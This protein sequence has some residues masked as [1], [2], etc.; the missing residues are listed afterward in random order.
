MGVCMGKICGTLT[1]QEAGGGH[2]THEVHSALRLLSGPKLGNAPESP[3]EWMEVL[4]D[5][6]IGHYWQNAAVT[7]ASERR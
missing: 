5:W 1:P 3:L 4:A 2:K 6:Q 7:R